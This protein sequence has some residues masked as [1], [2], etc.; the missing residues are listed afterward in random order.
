MGISAKTLVIN[1]GTAHSFKAKY[2]VA[3]CATSTSKELVVKVKKGRKG[4]KQGRKEGRKKEKK[5]NE[6]QEYSSNK[7]ERIGARC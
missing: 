4:R 3:L 6:Y 1:S 7:S 5:K 2:S